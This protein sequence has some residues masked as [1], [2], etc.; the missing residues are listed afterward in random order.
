QQ[1]KIQASGGLSDSDIDQMVKDAEQFAEEDKKRRAA[2]EAKNNAESLIH[3]TEG[4]LNEHGSK[5]DAELK[6]EIEAAIA[7]TKTAVEGGNPD[8]MT[9][10]ANALAQVAMKMGQKIYEQEQAAGAA[11]AGSGEAEKASNEDVVDAEFS[12]VD[13]T[14]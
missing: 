14:K 7:A 10:K 11:A 12:E 4:Q 1:I 2:A 5:I 13:D 9:E 3:S 6:S 8:E